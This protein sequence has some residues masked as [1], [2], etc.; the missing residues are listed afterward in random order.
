[1][2]N[3][4]KYLVGYSLKKRVA[5][6]S[7][8]IVNIILFVLIVLLTN[9][10]NII[11]FFGG[12]FDEAVIVYLYDETGQNASE[13]FKEYSRDCNF[14]ITVKDS[15]DESKKDEMLKEAEALVILKVNEK[16]YVHADAY[17][18][19]ISLSNEMAL[20]NTVS[21]VK[22]HYWLIENPE[23]QSEL[24]EFNQSETIN[25]MR[26]ENDET[27][28]E[29]TITTV[30]S[31]FIVIPTFMLLI[32]LIQ[33]IG[34]DIIEE[35]S[36]RS[37]EVI[38]SNVP[39]GS[40][41]ASKIVSTVIFM[42]IQGGLLIAYAGIGGFLAFLIGGGANASI[43]SGVMAQLGITSN[44]MSHI[45]AKLPVTIITL[46]LF[47]LVGYTMYLVLT[48]VLSSMATSMDNFQSYQTPV[49]LLLLVGFYAAI[50]GIQFDGAVFL[51][52]LGYIPFFSPIL[53]PIL[54][55]S[56][57]YGLLEIIISFVILAITTFLIIYFGMPLYK[58]SILDYSEGSLIQKLKRVIKKAKYVE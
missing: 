58:A 4:F 42:I 47:I 22:Y 7:F 53:A 24:T 54:F 11:N 51:K 9:L 14:E 34:I 1:M 20:T 26:S 13:V 28:I 48:A 12:D 45:L 50:F 16:G 52:I 31:M 33:F 32:F 8:L 15:F 19:E 3:K 18:N 10:G 38:I 29:K 55:L 40:H 17:V 43:D 23:L 21:S 5:K 25:Y 44:I 36:S 27:A 6:K 41:F 35:K 37:I 2:D 57:S 39:S 49:M 46:L 30:L 56:G